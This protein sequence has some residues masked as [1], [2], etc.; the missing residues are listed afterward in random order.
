MLH[1]QTKK[2]RSISTSRLIPSGLDIATTVMIPY[3]TIPARNRID[4]IYVGLEEANKTTLKCV[5]VGTKHMHSSNYF[6]LSMCYRR[7]QTSRSKTP[8]ER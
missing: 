7:Y 6:S 1:T 4:M 3:G 2:K 8:L 5:L